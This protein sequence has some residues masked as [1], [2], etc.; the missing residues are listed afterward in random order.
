MSC[1]T[2]M[3]PLCFAVVDSENSDNWSWFMG[4]LAEILRPQNRVVTIISDRHK[5][6]RD[7]IWSTFP[8]WPHAFCLYHLK[9]N[10]RSLYLGSKNNDTREKV[11]SI[12]TKCA[13][14][15]KVSFFTKYIGELESIGG[16]EIKDFLK[17]L[18]PKNYSNAHFL[19]NR[20]GDLCSNVAESFNS[21]ILN[22]RTL[23]IFQLV[24]GIHTKMMTLIGDRR[25]KSSSWSSILCPK[26]EKMLELYDKGT[27]RGL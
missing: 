22:Q 4:K 5:G 2:G 24:D 10:I 15:S 26:H 17:S 23:L 11:L 20:Y 9:N 8:M 6:L 7:A 14:T 3:Y 19:G 12:F 1:V 25:A 21:W 13:Y 16:D 18:P 27:K